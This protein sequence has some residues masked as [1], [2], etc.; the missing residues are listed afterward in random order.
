M[1]ALVAIVDVSPHQGIGGDVLLCDFLH[2]AMQ[3]GL[4][5][6]PDAALVGERGIYLAIR[7]EGG[8]VETFQ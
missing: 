8:E 5:D 3:T 7:E 6:G 2:R 4:H 1:P